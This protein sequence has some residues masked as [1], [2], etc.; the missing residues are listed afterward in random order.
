[1]KKI[2]S[3]VFLT[4]LLSTQ[5]LSV[6]LKEALIVTYK[7]NTELNA[8]REN[9]NVSKE[10]LNISKSNYLPS[11]TISGS[12]SEEETNKLTNQ[13][14][15]NATI[16]DVNP[17][18]KS[19][20]V[21]QTLLDFGRGADLQKNRIG[22]RLAE[23][24]LLKKEQDILYK[25]IEAY[26]GLIFANEKYNINKK[27]VNLLE[28]QVETDK[29]RLDRGQITIADLAQSESSLA[30]AKANFAEAQSNLFTS[31]LNYENVIGS[32][33]RADDLKKSSNA[34]AVIPK[35]VNEAIEF[36]KKNNPDLIISKLEFEQSE[37]DVKLAKSDMAPTAT[38]SLE[39]S[40]NEDLSTTYDEREKDILKATVSWP[41]YSGGKKIAT[42]KKNKNLKSRKRLLLDNELKT[43]ETKVASA[44]SYLQ[45]SKSFLASV[46]AQVKAAEIANEGI[47]AEYER[48]SRT[49]LD[50]IQSNTLLLNA[51]VSLANSERNY[52]LSQYDLLRSIGLL[53]SDYLKIR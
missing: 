18:T 40:Y 41:F 36:S 26:T 27:N 42:I 8:E 47:A 34:I 28:K 13:S 44:W 29:V 12:K 22:V 14:G 16:N 25:A 6:T 1:M 17:L 4:L 45:A 50:V 46:Q 7:N 2:I 30:G 48:G 49:T 37:K 38:L 24:K 15:G 11:L 3:V 32:V 5:A 19:I 9:I 20:K 35:S 33:F 10:D 51:E 52:L 23:A 39:R 31:K 53:N 21:E 43:N